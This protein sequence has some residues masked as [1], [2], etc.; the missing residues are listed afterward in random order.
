MSSPSSMVDWDLAGRAPRKLAG[1]GPETTREDAAAVVRELHEAAARAVAHVEGLTGLKPPQG[2]PLPEAAVVDRPG[3]SD[4]NT[5]GMAALLN[6]LVNALTEK[7]ESRPGPWA[8]A[9]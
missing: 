6:P 9:I 8:T 2:G 3:W 7:Q 4:A 5:A 1:P